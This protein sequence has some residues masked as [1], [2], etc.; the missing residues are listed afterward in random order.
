MRNLHST[1][2]WKR[3]NREIKE[4]TSIFAMKCTC[5]VTYL[6]RM[7][8]IRNGEGLVMRNLL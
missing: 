1:L 7:H 3:K 5:L 4:I 2:E 8:C 6:R